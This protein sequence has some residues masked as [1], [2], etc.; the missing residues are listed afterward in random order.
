MKDR[1]KHTTLKDSHYLTVTPDGRKDAHQ[2]SIGFNVGTA[3]EWRQTDRAQACIWIAG[4][5]IFEGTF[6]ELQN[7][8]QYPPAA[9]YK[10]GRPVHWSY[11]KAKEHFVLSAD[12]SEKYGIRYTLAD[13]A[14]NVFCNISE[15]EILP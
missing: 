14:G 4:K 9:L 13:R 6:E 12:E 7:A 5:P 11:G 8:L 1:V 10:P 3:D 2:L 15:G